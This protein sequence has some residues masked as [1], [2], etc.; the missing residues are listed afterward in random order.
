MLHGRAPRSVSSCRC[1][2]VASEG[3]YPPLVRTDVEV[4]ATLSKMK[5]LTDWL[6]KQDGMVGGPHL[7]WQDMC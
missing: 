3:I 7:S 4:N 2:L 1:H 6:Q 5:S